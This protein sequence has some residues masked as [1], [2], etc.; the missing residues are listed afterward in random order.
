MLH[1][2]LTF[3]TLNILSE[4]TCIFIDDEAW[5][6]E[7]IGFNGFMVSWHFVLQCRLAHT[8]HS[9]CVSKSFRLEIFD[10]ESY[11]IFPF[12]MQELGFDMVRS[13]E[14]LYHE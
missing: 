9:Q 3:Y 10:S 5:S 14:V 11:N 7:G 6:I 12:N 2:H 8:I 13:A 4:T 1:D